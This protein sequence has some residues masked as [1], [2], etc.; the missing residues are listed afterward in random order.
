MDTVTLTL[1]MPD[2]PEPSPVPHGTHWGCAVDSQGY[3]RVVAL[4][5]Y[6]LAPEMLPEKFKTPRE[7]IDAAER[8]EHGIH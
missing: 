4:R 1:D 7:A 8:M 3:H 5:N 2:Q 6:A